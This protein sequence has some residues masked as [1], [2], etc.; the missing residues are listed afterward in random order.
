[1]GP[2]FPR[3]GHVGRC[4]GDTA[5]QWL[6]LRSGLKIVVQT[7]RLGRQGDFVSRLLVLIYWLFFFSVLCLF[8]CYFFFGSSSILSL[9]LLFLIGPF[10]GLLPHSLYECLDTNGNGNGN[11]KGTKRC[12][13]WYWNLERSPRMA[14]RAVVAAD[15]ILQGQTNSDG[16]PLSRFR[17]PC[18]LR[19]AADLRT[20]GWMDGCTHMPME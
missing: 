8:I 3:G 5:W 10:I 14:C 11:G 17:P 18:Y 15:D 6:V 2:N 4:D 7:E 1:M 20:D 9:F 13:D 12:W 19:R 16:Y